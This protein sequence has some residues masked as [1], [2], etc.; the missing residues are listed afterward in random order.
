MFKAGDKII[1]IDVSDVAERL[2][3]GRAYEVVDAGETDHGYAWVQLKAGGVYWAVSRFIHAGGL[4]NVLYSVD[5]RKRDK[6][7]ND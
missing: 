1:C 5:V 7:D 4:A 2:E 6:D 3:L